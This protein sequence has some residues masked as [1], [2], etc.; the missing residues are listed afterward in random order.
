MNKLIILLFTILGFS[1]SS[2]AQQR[3]DFNVV[4]LPNTITDVKNGVDIN[5]SSVE[6]ICYGTYGADDQAMKRNARFLA[7]Y[8]EEATGERLPQQ[9][10]VSRSITH[11]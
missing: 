8:I 1:L 4:P 2:S 3:A 7:D 10:D 5:L 9:I 6:C 11:I